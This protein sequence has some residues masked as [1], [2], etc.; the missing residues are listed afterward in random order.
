MIAWSVMAVLGTVSVFVLTCNYIGT[1]RGWQTG[2]NYSWGP[3]VGGVFG[4]LALLV[5]PDP[6][7]RIWAWVPLVLDLSIPAFLYAVFVLKIFR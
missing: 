7:W 1:I 3:F 4:S 5:C 2:R 6:R